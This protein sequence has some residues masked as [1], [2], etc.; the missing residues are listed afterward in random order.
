LPLSFMLCFLSGDWAIFGSRSERTEGEDDIV[1]EC[2]SKRLGY[3][4]A[5]TLNIERMIVLT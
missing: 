2:G 3:V 1:R 5:G 4:D